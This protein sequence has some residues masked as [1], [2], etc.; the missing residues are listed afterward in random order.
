MATQKPLAKIKHGERV[1]GAL[2]TSHFFTDIA[3]AT[4]LDVKTLQKVLASLHKNGY[5]EKDSK[6]QWVRKPD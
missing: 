4:S 3:H 1:L 6:S 2:T 5:I